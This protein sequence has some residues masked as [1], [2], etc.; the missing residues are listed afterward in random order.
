[1]EKKGS[2][3][4]SG[5]EEISASNPSY[6]L[7]NVLLEQGTRA[8]VCV[9]VCVWMC[10]C[11]DVCVRMCVCVDVC[12]CGCVCVWMCVCGCVCADVCVCGC[13]CV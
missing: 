12:V 6:L 4:S 8:R 10:V 5:G 11:V 1:M 13:V 2:H 9:R 7:A 3:V